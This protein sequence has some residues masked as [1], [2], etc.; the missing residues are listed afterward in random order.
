[1]GKKKNVQDNDPMPFETAG[2]Y[3]TRSG[4][5]RKDCFA[6]VYES[7]LRSEAFTKLTYRQQMLYILCRVQI[8]GKRTPER[9][10]PEMPEFQ[11]KDVFFLNWASVSDEYGFYPGSSSKNFYMDMNALIEHGFVDRLSSGKRRRTKSVYRFSER[12]KNWKPAS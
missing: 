3:Y 7:V 6:R 9:E 10:Y 11:G 12:W 2:G 5:L 8:F 4:Q 1:M